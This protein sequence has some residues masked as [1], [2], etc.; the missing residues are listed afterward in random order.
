MVADLAALPNGA[1]H[2][3]GALVGNILTDDEERGRHFV[4][5]QH[6]EHLGLGGQVGPVVKSKG[7]ILDR[8]LGSAGH[9]QRGKADH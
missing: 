7:K 6:V 3:P 9:C 4:L 5:G 2:V 8:L 1:L